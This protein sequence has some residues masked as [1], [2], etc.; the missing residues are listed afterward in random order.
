MNAVP[1]RTAVVGFGRV[2][3]G[4]ADDPRMAAHYQYAT[5][6]QVLRAHPA[7][8]FAAVVDA[9]PDARENA[10]A[11]WSVPSVA[12]TPAGL[13]AAAGDIEVVVL[14]TPPQTRVELLDGFPRLRAVLVEKPLGVTLTD[15][16]RFLDE[17]RR[18]DILVQVNLWRRADTRFRSLAAGELHDM[19]GAAQCAFGVY[20]NG[21]QNN[22]THMVDLVRMLLGEITAVE[23]FGPS[24]PFRAGPIP[25]DVNPAFALS[26]ASGAAAV[27]HPLRFEHYRENSL[28]IWGERGRLAVE[29]EGL[30][31][32]RYGR[33]DSRSTTGEREIVCDAPQYLETTVGDALYHMYTNLAEAVH[34]AGRLWSPGESALRTTLV[35]DAILRAVA[36]C[37]PVGINEMSDAMA[38]TRDR[39]AVP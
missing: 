22:G 31:L 4:Y 3:C 21:L 24:A 29:N 7:F 13:G 10:R 32:V 36:E 38:L 28:D 6:A 35:V 17:C 26:M 18:R 19:L 12:E 34:G 15:C 16:A 11:R 30:T 33:A 8:R 23:S 39:S 9:D 14:A 37:R 27:F 20:G 1:L 2:S 25:G 5:H